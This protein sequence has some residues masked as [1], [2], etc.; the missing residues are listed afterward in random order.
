[1]PKMEREVIGELT[2]EKGSEPDV[3][4]EQL[5]SREIL[6]VLNQEDQQVAFRVAQ[7]LPV[8]AQVVDAVFPR[9][10]VGGRLVYIGS[11]TSGR[12]GVLDAAECPPTFGVSDQTVIG[13]IAGGDK[14]IRRAVERAEDDGHQGQ[15]DL[16]S[17]H[18]S[19]R[20]N[21]VGISASG[22]TPYVVGALRYA[23]EQKALTVALT[24][25]LDS[26]MGKESRYAI[27]VD[28]GPEVL[29]GSTR[30]KAGT[31]QKMVLN[32]MSTALMVR[33]GKTH[34]NMMVDLRPTNQKLIDRAKRMIMDVC[35]CSMDEASALFQSSKGHVKLAIVM[36]QRGLDYD[37]AQR[38]LQ[39]S[40][41]DLQIAL[42]Q[43]AGG[44]DS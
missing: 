35:G 42:G 2:T 8:I 41:N 7:V 34:R 29:A 1:M 30:L 26:L 43:S 14:A 3:A 18:L 44:S 33:L 15:L 5:S 10:A 4:L 40:H 6:E 25:N 37:A 19:D 38:L 20:D 21:V 22:R 23:R 17:I 11:G 12:L 9:M 31:A 39:E 28:T 24:N 27:E 36:N 32:M 16:E 13:L